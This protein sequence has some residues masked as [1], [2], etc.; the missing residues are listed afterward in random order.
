MPTIAAEGARLTTCRLLLRPLALADA[1]AI[2]RLA[3]DPEVARYTASIPHPYPPGAAEAFIR[4]AAQGGEIVFAIAHRQS[5]NL[6]GCIGIEID[7][8]TRTGDVGYWIGRAY[9]GRGYATEALRAVTEHAFAALGCER[10]T[11]AAVAQNHASIRVQ[12]KAGYA[13]VGSERRA[14]P[15]R[16]R[17]IEVEV[18]ARLRPGEGAGRKGVSRPLL[19]VA[20]VALV[21]ADGRVLLA[22]RPEGK[23][24]AGLWEFPGG[25]V[26][27]DET[28]ESAL[29]RELKEE[30]GIDVE[31]ACLAPLTFASHAYEDV[32]L[33]M[34]LFV[35]RRWRGTVA[36]EEGQELA[37][38]RPSRLADYPMPPADAP[39]A[40]VLRDML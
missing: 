8:A 4:G 36:A 38:V 7:R 20:A 2:E 31:Q 23:A 5:G 32:H 37:W 27:A 40:A 35:C 22:R 28:P 3:G 26:L 29:I 11:A 15:A 13:P 39:I 19:L 10:V 34:P 9:W 21:D 30:L 24:M 17:P 25:K 1:P 33:L 12:E 6:I 18:R 14:A 16:G